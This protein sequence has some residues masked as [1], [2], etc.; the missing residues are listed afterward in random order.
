MPPSLSDTVSNLV[1]LIIVPPCYLTGYPTCQVRLFRAF[2][3][4]CTSYLWWFGE[5]GKTISIRWITQFSLGWLLLLVLTDLLTKPPYFPLT[6]L[7]GSI[8]SSLFLSLWGF[9]RSYSDWYLGQSVI[10]V[11]VYSRWFDL[12]SYISEDFITPVKLLQAAEASL[13]ADRISYYHKKL[14]IGTPIVR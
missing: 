4:F 2:K 7:S 5:L 6:Y 13:G 12:T 8:A 1:G 3:C 9:W 11:H 14:G 10:V